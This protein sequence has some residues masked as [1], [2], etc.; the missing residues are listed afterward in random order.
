MTTG[1]LTS[2][3]LNYRAEVLRAV[4]IFR[5]GVGALLLMAA[6]C[7]PVR[8]E[9]FVVQT[10]AIAGVSPAPVAGMPAMPRAGIGGSG[11]GAGRAPITVT[12]AGEG[13]SDP[14]LDPHATFQWTETIPGGGSC[15]QATFTGTFSCTI[16]GSF[17]LGPDVLDGALTLTL[18]GSSEAQALAATQSQLLAFDQSMKMVLVAPLTG[19]L[20]CSTQALALDVSPSTTEPLSIERQFAWLTLMPQPIVTGTVKGALDRRTQEIQGDVTLQF[21]PG[22][23]CIGTFSVR[24]AL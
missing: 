5:L 19:G 11:G 20:N 22:P 7:D 6:G 14:R 15:A 2:G 18:S 17:L 13:G 8:E 16:D 9:L 12:F 3:L 1:I 24:A 21:E 23:Q 4:Q 10:Q